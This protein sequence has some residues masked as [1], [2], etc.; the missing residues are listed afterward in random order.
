MMSAADI[1][2]QS[3]K[4]NL[5]LSDIIAFAVAVDIL[6]GLV[7]VLVPLLLS[8]DRFNLVSELETMEM[9]SVA[10][11]VRVVVSTV[12]ALTIAFSVA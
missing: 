2:V 11:A 1:T 10:G 12:L 7:G 9:L 8:S 4:S 3:A 6:A 5:S